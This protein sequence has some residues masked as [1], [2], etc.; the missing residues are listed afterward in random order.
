[1]ASQTNAEKMRAKNQRIRQRDAIRLE[2]LSMIAKLC[3]GSAQEI[4]LAALAAEAAV[5]GKPGNPNSVRP[6]VK[7][8]ATAQDKSYVSG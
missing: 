1:M 2:A 7:P 8:A 4:A 3:T 5:A 6:R